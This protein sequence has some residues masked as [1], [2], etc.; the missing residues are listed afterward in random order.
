MLFPILLYSQYKG[1]REK[2]TKIIYV[3]Y[4]Y[5]PG[6]H[7]HKVFITKQDGNTHDNYSPYIC[8]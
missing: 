1:I 7:T 2:K 4:Y 5:T 8:N 6:T 3:M